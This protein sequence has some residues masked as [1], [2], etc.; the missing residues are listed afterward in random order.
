M[1]RNG[2]WK[3]FIKVEKRDFIEKI[4]IRITHT[5]SAFSE[6]KFLI[7]NKTQNI[8]QELIKD[9]KAEY[10]KNKSGIR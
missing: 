2:H 3:G 4:F 7:G 10:R 5:P 6:S 1:G 9:G 8:K